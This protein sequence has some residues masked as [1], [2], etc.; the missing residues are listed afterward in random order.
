MTDTPFREDGPTSAHPRATSRREVLLGAGVLVAGATV[1]AGCGAGASTGSTGPSAGPASV[2]TS[3]VPV[4]GGT[5]LTSPPIV[6]TQPTAGTYKAFSSICPH[7]GCPVAAI[8]SGLILCP[9]HG[10]EFDIATGDVKAGPAPRG[11]TPLSATVS[12]GTV[13]VS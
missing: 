5:I 4:G 6:V 13:T 12:G 3:Q 2:P 11:L 7:A 10:S 1:L 9:C 8:Q